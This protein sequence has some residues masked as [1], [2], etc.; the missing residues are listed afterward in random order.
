MSPNLLVSEGK[1]FQVES[2]K[3]KA[4]FVEQQGDQRQEQ[5]LWLLCS[6]MATVTC[7]SSG[8]SGRDPPP[9]AFHDTVTLPQAGRAKAV[10]KVK[11]REG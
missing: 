3:D 4:V 8:C 2:S 9:R 10:R 7:A 1:A 6:E 11:P 5:G